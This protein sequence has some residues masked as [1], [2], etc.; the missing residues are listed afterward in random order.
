MANS[1]KRAFS[2]QSRK[3][4]VVG[5]GNKLLSDEGSGVKTIEMLE[6]E[7]NIPENFHLLDGG[8]AGYTLIDC[9]KDFE[10][11]IIIDAVK[12]GNRPGTIY[13]LSFE[14]IMKRPD[15]KLSGH[16]IDLPEVLLLAKKLGELPQVL[17]IGIEPENI[18][19]GM[20]LSPH[21][22]SATDKV[23]KEICS[24]K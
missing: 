14:D 16:Q 6:K 10:R 22:K 2:T 9:M 8:T 7:R 3:T 18:G 20:E 13:H 21:V 15:L 4:L 17:L 11:I 5:L 24:L 19:Y 1:K 12:G 23:V